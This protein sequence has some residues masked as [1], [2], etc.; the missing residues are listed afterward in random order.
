MKNETRADKKFHRVLRE[1]YR[2]ELFSSNGKRV[3]DRERAIAIAFSEARKIDPRYHITKHANGTKIKIDNTLQI[4]FEDAWQHYLNYIASTR[5]NTKPLS[6]EQWLRTTPDGLKY[7]KRMAQLIRYNEIIVEP[8]MNERGTKISNND[9]H[10][11]G[12]IRGHLHRN[13]GVRAVIVDTKRPVELELDE[14]VITKGVA[15]ADEDVVCTGKPEGIASRLNERYNGDK[16][17]NKN[18]TCHL[19]KEI[20]ERGKK[21]FRPEN[22]YNNQ[23]KWEK[24]I[25]LFNREIKGENPDEY[26]LRKHYVVFVQQPNSERIIATKHGQKLGYWDESLNEGYIYDEPKM[27]KQKMENGTKIKSFLGIDDESKIKRQIEHEQQLKNNE[28]EHGKKIETN[29]VILKIN[30][31]REF[32]IVSFLTQKSFCELKLFKY[33]DICIYSGP[34]E[35]MEKLSKFMDAFNIHYTEF[36][37]HFEFDD[38]MKKQLPSRI[39]NK[40]N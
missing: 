35:S 39:K 28:M 3:T 15:R 14:L 12:K 21:I 34:P 1:Y 26:K 33:D 38:W 22:V 24:D 20:M 37:N 31:P 27:L 18:A 2:N 36:D 7:N 6:F 17:S 30:E 9:K 4:V 10:R 32:A 23:K 11:G 16:I 19:K 25:E 40:F 13:G 5:E 29:D 8:Q